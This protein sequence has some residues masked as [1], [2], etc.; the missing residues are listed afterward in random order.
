ML[1]PVI[2]WIKFGLGVVKCAC[3][4][5][6]ARLEIEEHDGGQYNQQ[7]RA[8]RHNAYLFL[9]GGQTILV[10]MWMRGRKTVGDDV[11][12]GVINGVWEYKK[13]QFDGF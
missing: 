3:F 9:L 2:K 11:C 5:L 12:W 7:N 8:T 1:F 6:I 10:R 4:C 13:G